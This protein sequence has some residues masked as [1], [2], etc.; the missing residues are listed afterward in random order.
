[1]QHRDIAWPRSGQ[2]SRSDLERARHAGRCRLLGPARSCARQRAARRSPPSSAT[3]A[4]ASPE[5]RLPAAASPPPAQAPRRSPPSRSCRSAPRS[6]RNSRCR[7]RSPIGWRSPARRPRCEAALQTGGTTEGENPWTGEAQASASRREAPS[8]TPRPRLRGNG[9]VSITIPSPPIRATAKRRTPSAG[10]GSRQARGARGYRNC[11]TAPRKTAARAPQIGIC[12]SQDA[13]CGTA[14]RIGR[15]GPT[16]AYREDGRPTPWLRSRWKQTVRRA[17][18]R[19]YT[20][21]FLL[22]LSQPV[23]PLVGTRRVPATPATLPIA[24][25]RPASAGL[26]GQPRA[27]SP[28][29]SHSSRA[30]CDPATASTGCR[31][32]SSRRSDRGRSAAGTPQ[33]QQP[34]GS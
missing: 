3:G 11:D 9:R 32:S 10:A 28:R 7:H 27:T 8:V 17:L 22:A 25:A 15:S 31:L 12:G 26:R 21:S 23:A 2:M 24:G 6:P 16:R 14:G 18:A 1:V 13:I 5:G 30:V 29:C 34:R 19:A 33:E 4:S 20:R